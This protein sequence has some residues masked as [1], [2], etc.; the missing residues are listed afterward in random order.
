MSSQSSRFSN[1]LYEDSISTVEGKYVYFNIWFM[2]K[3][4]CQY[5]QNHYVLTKPRKWKQCFRMWDIPYQRSLNTLV[6][7]K[8]W[9]EEYFT[10]IA[11][12]QFMMTL[13]LTKWSEFNEVC[14][15]HSLLSNFLSQGKPLERG[16]FLLCLGQ[17]I[18]IFFPLVTKI[19]INSIPWRNN[20]P[21]KLKHNLLEMGIFCITCQSKLTL[22]NYRYQ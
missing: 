10:Y 12:W 20:F 5:W 8:I 14:S 16:A 13:R 1:I 15:T 2:V 7:S 3:I 22:M 11:N 4:V 18:W 19:L 17:L 21:Y 6:K 9:N